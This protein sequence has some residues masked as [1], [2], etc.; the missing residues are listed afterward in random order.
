M[1]RSLSP[2]PEDSELLL[3]K[4]MVL[5]LVDDPSGAEKQLKAIEA[6]WPEWDRPYLVHGLVL[7]HAQRKSEAMQKIRIA[8]ALGSRELAA[9]CAASRLS[10]AVNTKC[11]CEAGLRAFASGSCGIQASASRQ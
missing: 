11:A 3:T 4:A 9:E 5:G 1:E 6:R 2:A 10:G 8:I 7:E